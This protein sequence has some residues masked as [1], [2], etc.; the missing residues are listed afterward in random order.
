M[1]TLAQRNHMKA[2]GEMFLH[3]ERQLHYKQLRPMASIHKTESEIDKLLLGGGEMSFDC[4]EAVTLICKLVGLKDPNNAHYNGTGNTQMMYDH[5]PHY[6]DAKRAL[7]GAL[8]L[9][10]IP[11]QLDTQHV[12]FVYRRDPH[13]PLMWSMGQESDPRLVRF[14]VEKKFHHD[15]GVFLSIAGL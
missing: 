2:I 7:I 8:G 5:L 13:D 4:S 12:A 14:S 3:H 1:S 9:F 10:G 6:T 11:G 15:H